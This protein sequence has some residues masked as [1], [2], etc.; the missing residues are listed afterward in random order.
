S[1]NHVAHNLEPEQVKIGEHELY[2]FCNKGCHMAGTLGAEALTYKKRKQDS[3][4]T[5]SIDNPEFDRKNKKAR[6]SATE[7]EKKFS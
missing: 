1:T 7:E 3:M 5:S 2:D 4:K 6:T